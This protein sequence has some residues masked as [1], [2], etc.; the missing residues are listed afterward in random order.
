MKPKASNEHEDGLLEYLEDIIGTAE[1]KE[2][3]EEAFSQLEKA[4]EERAE[5][6]NRV[7]VVENE[8]KSLQVRYDERL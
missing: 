5:R 3:I 7:K 2:R 1:Y 8:L 4:T 6:L